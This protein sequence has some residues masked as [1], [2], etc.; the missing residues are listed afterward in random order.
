M[1]RSSQCL[2]F[3]LGVRAR[4]PLLEIPDQVVDV[5][6]A[7]RKP[8]RAGAN[9]RRLELVLLEL[10]MRGARGMD[11]Q[12]LRVADVGQ[13]RPQRH[14]ADEVLARLTAAFELERK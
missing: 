2:R 13:V 11:D 6:D 14:A 5:L 8:D 12:A 7:D 1:A 4:E 3:G 10:A 9:A